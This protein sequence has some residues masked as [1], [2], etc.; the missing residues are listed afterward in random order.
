M[1]LISNGSTIFDNGS[2][3]AG[4][5]GSLNFISK[6]TASSS[7]SVEFTS[8]IDSSYD[9]YVFYFV[10]MHPSSDQS[11]LQFQV[12]TNGGS[13]YGVTT[14]STFFST[15]LRDGDGANSFSYNTGF[16]LAQ[17]TSFMQASQSTNIDSYSSVSGYLHLVNPSSTSYTKNYT[18]ITNEDAQ[19]TGDPLSQN[20]YFQGYFDT[21]SAINAIKFRFNS[22]NIDAGEILLF[23]IN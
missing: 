19:T 14:T 13:S 5:G 21:T 3:S 22:G 18:G 17:S 8:G 23:G 16:D 12:S 4:F 15:Y 9:E 1:G 7:A 6:A 2:M 20:N 10:N 11:H